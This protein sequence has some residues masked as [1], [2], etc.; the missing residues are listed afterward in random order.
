MGS[1]SGLE[2]CHLVLNLG[3]PSSGDPMIESPLQEDAAL[4]GRP[5]RV[6][7]EAGNRFDLKELTKILTKPIKK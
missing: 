5:H 1:R 2:C 7:A 3:V 4:P 6:R